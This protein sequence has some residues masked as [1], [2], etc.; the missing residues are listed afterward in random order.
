MELN[1]R[2]VHVVNEPF[3]S[4]SRPLSVPLVQ[5]SAFA[6]DSAADLADAMAGP[7]GRYVYSRRGNSD[8]AGPGADPRGARR[9]G[10]GDR[11]RLTAWAPSAACSYALLRPGDRVVCPA[12]PVRRATHAVAVGPGRA[13]RDRGLSG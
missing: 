7:D 9:R 1:T 12:L 13:V 11:L 8:R 10:G 2:A 3:P 5:S 4:G 6:F